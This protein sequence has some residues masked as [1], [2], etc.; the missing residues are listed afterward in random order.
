MGA[1]FS[2]FHMLTGFMKIKTVKL[3]QVEIDGV[4]LAISMHMLIWT[5]THVNETVLYTLSAP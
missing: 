1:N 3:N 2:Q 4:M 5:S